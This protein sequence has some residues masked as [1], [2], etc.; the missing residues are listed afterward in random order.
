MVT[1]KEIAEK[2][3]AGSSFA[4]KAGKRAVNK[5]IGKPLEYGLEIERNE[6]L[7]CFENEDAKV[8][9]QSFLG[10]RNK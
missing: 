9:L 8:G 6:F 4:L 2:V 3:N 5:G 10:N 7:R 1:A